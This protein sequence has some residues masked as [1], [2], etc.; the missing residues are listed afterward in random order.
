MAHGVTSRLAPAE[1][2]VLPAE[3]SVGATP[4]SGWGGSGGT[5]HVPPEA[6]REPEPLQGVCRAF[7]HQEGARQELQTPTARCSWQPQGH[8]SKD[9]WNCF[10]SSTKPGM[11]PKALNPTARTG[12]AISI[13][14]ETNKWAGTT[15]PSRSGL[16]PRPRHC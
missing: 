10:I 12:L 9:T 7:S 16:S 1:G 14:C 4:S 3:N 13:E 5:L 11:D 15:N 6:S 8:T 2:F